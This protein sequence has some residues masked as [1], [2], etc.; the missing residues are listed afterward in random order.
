MGASVTFLSPARSFPHD[1]GSRDGMV[2]YRSSAVNALVYDPVV[3]SIEP[4]H[5]RAAAI[6]VVDSLC[7]ALA[8]VVEAR[9]LFVFA[10]ILL[11]MK[12]EGLG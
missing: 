7:L 4:N 10:V 2:Q 8:L 12:T 3:D 6:F 5:E 9:L 1:H 11:S